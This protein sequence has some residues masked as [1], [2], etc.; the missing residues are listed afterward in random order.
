MKGTSLPRELPPVHFENGFLLKILQEAPHCYRILSCERTTIRGIK[1][2][3]SVNQNARMDC[4]GC[5]A[6]SAEFPRD[7]FGRSA[8]SVVRFVSRQLKTNPNQPT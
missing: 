6:E 5:F 1:S 7:L 3:P 2:L 4:T 8:Q